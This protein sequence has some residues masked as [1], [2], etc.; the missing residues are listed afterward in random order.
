M[1]TSWSFSNLKANPLEG[2]LTDVIVSVDYRIAYY[3]SGSPKGSYFAGTAAFAPP[4]P[5]EFTDFNE[6][7]EAIM[8]AFVETSL[9]D[10]L[11]TIQAE[12]KAAY[13]NPVVEMPLPWSNAGDVF[14]AR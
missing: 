11:D 14:A 13:D 3:E 2:G 10:E 9:G 8:I 6:I 7:S 1:T 5:D 4:D 12:L